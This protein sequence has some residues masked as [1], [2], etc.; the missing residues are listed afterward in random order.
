MTLSDKNV[1]DIFVI[2]I[3]G[4]VDIYNCGELKQLFSKKIENG[5]RKFI[6]NMDKLTY[7][8]SSGIGT[9]IFM[10]TTVSKF[11]GEMVIINVK[12]SVKKIFDL[13]KL[14]T[15]FKIMEDEQQGVEYFKK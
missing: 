13:T 10:K 3:S 1:G 5:G 8:D 14:T 7:I 15:F 12:D 6:I 2:E 9:L 4:E 11:K